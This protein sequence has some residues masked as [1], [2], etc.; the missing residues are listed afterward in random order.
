M[1]VAVLYLTGTWHIHYLEKPEK[2]YFELVKNIC[3]YTE[4]NHRHFKFHKYKN[5]KAFYHEIPV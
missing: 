1:R 4:T 3:Q 2:A 5:K